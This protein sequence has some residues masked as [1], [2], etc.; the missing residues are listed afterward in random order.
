VAL[1]RLRLRAVNSPLMRRKF[2]TLAAAVLSALLAAACVLWVRSHA[3]YFALP[4]R[5][6]SASAPDARLHCAFEC[7]DTRERPGFGRGA[8]QPVHIRVSVNGR[9]VLDEV[10]EATANN[11][12]DFSL[13]LP[14][15]VN[16][17][18]IEVPGETKCTFPAYNDAPT[19]ARVLF[20]YGRYDFR[21]D[22]KPD[23]HPS[24]T[25]TLSNRPQPTF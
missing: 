4:A 25:Y 1:P 23:P 6:V 14:E 17:V 13:T 10:H 21:G 5:R 19:W 8:L 15:A 24:M 7:N 2:F 16:R 22:P 18:E 3:D 20:W 9:V 11:N 12:F